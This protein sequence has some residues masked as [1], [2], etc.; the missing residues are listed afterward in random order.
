M[1][2]VGDGARAK[3]AVMANG[4]WDREVDLLVAGAGPG[5]MT[6]A[7]VAALEG[8]DV[9]I[10]EKSEQVGGTGATSAG[11]L[12]I[13]ENT[14]SRDAGFP[15]SAAEAGRYLDALI[16]GDADPVRAAYLADGP[17]VIDDLVARTDLEFVA[18]GPHPDYR[19][20]LPG[21]AIAGRAIIPAPFDGRLLG[22]D[23]A[24][25][26]PPIDEYMLF[27]G[28]MVGKADIVALLGRYRSVANFAHSVGLILR[29]LADR[30]RFKRGT[31]LVMGNALVARLFHSLRKNGVPILFGAPLGDLVVEDGRV[32]GAVVDAAGGKIR[33]RARKGVVMATGG[34]AHNETYRA[35]FFPDPV[36]PRSLAVAE[37]TG[38]GL[39]IAERVGAAVEADKAGRGGLWTP[40]SVTTRKDGST[41][42][43]PHLVLD[44]AKP[45][46]IAV[47]GAGRRFVN[48]G[49]SYHDFVEAMFLA[50]EV[51]PSI[52]AYLICDSAFVAKYGIGNIHPGTR[53]LEPF[54]R[55]GY[56]KCAGTVAALAEKIGVDAE[57]LADTVARNNRFAAD[58]A[59]PDFGKGDTELSRFNGDPEHGPNPCLGPIQTPPFVAVAVWPSELACSAGITTTADGQVLD[60]DRAPIQGL[61]ACGND[62]GSVMAGT[63]PGPGTTLG[64]A[65]VFGYRAAKHAAG[66]NPR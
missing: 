14:Q 61:Y 29:Y 20:N 35:K 19:N 58:G 45:G 53:N 11:T 59:D 4:A 28:M 62:M 49:V 12:W 2:A 16:G 1:I 66:V 54:E 9:L 52:P 65:M 21:S 56:A 17:K 10:C 42:L 46:L 40:V 43:Y 60:R 64:P 5:G 27:G 41:G 50:H 3:G 36:P 39:A 33:V 24:R 30:L 47:N 23:F 22:G 18:C 48:E 63:Y 26:R 44:R 32:T 38:D 57:G 51:T 55:S 34:F 31:R 6:A 13:P 25:V 8:L 7:L 37:N 15:D